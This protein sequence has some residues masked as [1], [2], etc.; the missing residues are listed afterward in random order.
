MA[1]G[2]AARY[3]HD[4]KDVGQKATAEGVE[5]LK[6][7]SGPVRKILQELKG[8]IQSGMGY[9]GADNLSN[10]RNNAR[11]IRVSP[12]GQREASPHDVVEIKTGDKEV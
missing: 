10:L 8:G 9:L 6:E 1:E 11:Y 4:T 5:A 7:V 12:A 3:G 2:S